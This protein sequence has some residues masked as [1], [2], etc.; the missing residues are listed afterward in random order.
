MK[1][2]LLYGLNGVV[3][4][5]VTYALYVLLVQVIDYRIAVVISYSLGICLSYLLNGA[6]VFGTYGRFRLFVVVSLLLM[7]LNLA[8]TWS[9]AEGL[10]W[11]KELAQLPAIAVVFVVGFFVN[12]RFVFSARAVNGGKAT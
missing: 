7:A 9:V 10:H 12:R 11:P 1:K 8:I 6:I 3:N 5:V 2:F 4:T